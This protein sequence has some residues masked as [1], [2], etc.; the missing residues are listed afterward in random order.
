VVKILNQKRAKNG[1][2]KFSFQ[3]VFLGIS[4]IY[5][6]PY[7][8][9]CCSNSCCGVTVQC[10][11]KVD[12]M[13]STNVSEAEPLPLNCIT[14]RMQNTPFRKSFVEIIAPDY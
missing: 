2:K 8:R 4:Y 9:N 14:L 1:L 5:D 6:L 12:D 3:L 11:A 7:I 13:I 10:P